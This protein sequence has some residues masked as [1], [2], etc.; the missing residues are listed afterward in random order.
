MGVN[1]PDIRY[2]IIWGAARSILDLHQEAGRSGRDR[3][4]S[5]IIV[6][7]HGQQIGPCK[8]EVKHFLRTNGS[9]RIGAYQSLDR[10]IQSSFPLHDCCSYCSTICNCG[11]GSCEAPVLPFE[12]CTAAIQAVESKRRTVTA[13]DRNDLRTALNE[14]LGN[15]RD[16]ELAID[17]TSS[18]G[19]SQQLIDDVV[20]NCDHIFTVEDVLCSF[21]VFS[22]ANVLRILELI[23]EMFS[24]IPDLEETLASVS[25]CKCDSE[26]GFNLEEC[27]FSSGDSDEEPA[28]HSGEES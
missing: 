8:P 12:K 6:L 5:H 18:H 22:T 10:N 25:F 14:I 27:R 20:Q 17:E 16:Q 3:V 1:F 4:L 2:V 11:G 28:E 9:L 23:Q 19:F 26:I 7:Y 24:D 15:F 13:E 21:P